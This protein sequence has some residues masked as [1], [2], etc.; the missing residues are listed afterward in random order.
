[1][2]ENNVIA[3]IEDRR[4]KW[5]GQVKRMKNGRIPKMLLEWAA[6]GR[7]RRGT[8]REQWIDGVRRSLS[9][10]DLTEEDGE[11]RDFWR[12]KISLVKDN[13]FFVEKS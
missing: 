11:N 12:R 3:V 8:P 4:L 1:M 7:R 10:W 13:Y 6:E 2:V 5:F 9:R